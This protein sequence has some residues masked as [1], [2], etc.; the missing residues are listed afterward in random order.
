MAT[1]DKSIQAQDSG[2]RR[3][4]AGR[5]GSALTGTRLAPWVL[6]APFFI[7]LFAFSLGPGLYSLY[8]SLQSDQTGQFVGLDNYNT[9]IN[10]PDFQAAAGVIW[11]CVYTL[12]PFFCIIAT[13]VALVLDSKAGWGKGIIKLL[14]FL[15]FAIPATASTI[16]WAF[17]FSPD[18]SVFGP[19]LH[20]MGAQNILF[21][22][23]PTSLPYAIMNIVVWQN[24]GA[25]VIVL[26]ASLAGIPQELVEMARIEGAGA[27]GVVRHIKLP[28]LMPVLVLMVVSVTSYVLTLITEPYL[29]QNTLSISA[30]FTPNM[31]A[32][33]VSFQSGLFNLAAA[34]AML[35]LLIASVFAILFVGLSGMYRLQERD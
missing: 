2:V 1:A 21:F 26:T 32:Y 28:L 18:S 16:L 10:D 9:V 11:Q 17:N 3:S 27:L 34:A 8:N 13:I 14:I 6:V 31:W 7:L 29:L 22:S 30:S 23:T 35:L 24:V 4:R 5:R 12:A 20:R 15:P 25:W 19:F 33:N